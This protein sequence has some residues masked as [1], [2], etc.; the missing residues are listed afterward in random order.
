MSR[1]SMEYSR[2][3]S[4]GNRMNPTNRTSAL[5]IESMEICHRYGST[6][7][8]RTAI[9][10][11]GPRNKTSFLI[12][13]SSVT[14]SPC[15]GLRLH[16]MALMFVWGRRRT[17]VQALAT[18][19]LHLSRSQLLLGLHVCWKGLESPHLLGTIAWS[20]GCDYEKRENR[21][22]RNIYISGQTRSGSRS[23]I[24]SKGKIRKFVYKYWQSENLGSHAS[25]CIYTFSISMAG[26][27]LG[28]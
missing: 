24:L 15:H 5:A 2:V 22:P 12:P 10:S 7:R 11:E 21:T 8:K 17:I 1:S 16:W 18:C 26:F 6:H 25:A 23:D 13:S 14:S 20:H 4:S 27:L 19:F 9:I 3:C 28:I